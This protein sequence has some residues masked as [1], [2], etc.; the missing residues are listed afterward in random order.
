MNEFKKLPFKVCGFTHIHGHRLTLKN[1]RFKDREFI[2]DAPMH[3]QLLM[4]P[5]ITLVVLIY[6]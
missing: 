6:E 4:H 3:C 1:Y 2:A 5:Y